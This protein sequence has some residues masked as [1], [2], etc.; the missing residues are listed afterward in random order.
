MPLVNATV[1]DYYDTFC[2]PL[3]TEHAVS[4]HNLNHGYEI[5]DRSPLLNASLVFDNP[6]HKHFMPSPVAQ[7]PNFLTSIAR[8][9][10]HIQKIRSSSETLARCFHQQMSISGEAINDV[11]IHEIGWKIRDPFAALRSKAKLIALR[12]QK[13]VPIS[14]KAIKESIPVH[15]RSTTSIPNRHSFDEQ[16]YR[17]S[18]FMPSPY[19]IK[20]DRDKIRKAILK[21]QSLESKSDLPEQSHRD[22]IL[23]G[24]DLRGKRGRDESILK[25]SSFEKN[26]KKSTHKL[27]KPS[28]LP[29]ANNILLKPKIDFLKLGHSPGAKSISSDIQ[30]R[31]LTK[32]SSK[33]Y[34]GYELGPKPINESPFMNAKEK[35]RRFHKSGGSHSGR[36]TPKF[37][38]NEE[39]EK[40]ES[41]DECIFQF[42]T[43]AKP[44]SQ[45]RQR[46]SSSLKDLFS[47]EI[48]K[49]ETNS[50]NVEHGSSTVEINEMSEQTKLLHNSNACNSRSNPSIANCALNSPSQNNPNHQKCDLLQKPSS[51]NG[52]D[53]PSNSS[54]YDG[55]DPRSGAFSM[56]SRGA[57]GQQSLSGGCNNREPSR[58]LSDRD[59][60][61]GD[62][63]NRSLSTTEGTPDDKI[64]KLEPRILLSFE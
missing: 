45:T 49:K 40:N 53:T 27:S 50:N 35:I 13:S 44:P 64:G 21:S 17:S 51:F 1:N 42:P 23:G 12:T 22:D 33:F 52:N 30:P 55:R 48:E 7:N 28:T 4:L 29:S 2:L 5:D 10:K 8:S 20:I 14:L 57:G 11:N 24:G 39:N 62:S 18:H 56:N 36:G 47:G 46:R 37:K 58:S 16:V 38:V 3:S 15:S 25:K 31:L 43:S 60:R 9:K 59:A 26:S 19:K 41:G 54:E 61:E 34:S 6:D 63:F 32:Q